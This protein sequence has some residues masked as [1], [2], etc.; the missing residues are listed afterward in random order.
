MYVQFLSCDDVDNITENSAVTDLTATARSIQATGTGNNDTLEIKTTGA[1][2]DL[3]NYA[4][5]TGWIYITGWVDNGT[6]KN[7]EIEL[8]LDGAMASN[9]IKVDMSDYVDTTRFS[10]WQR[11]TIPFVDFEGEG[12]TIDSIRIKT[13]DI[14]LGVAP[15]YWLD[16]IK[17]QQTGTSVPFTVA[18]DKGTWLHV[19]TI[20]FTF[21]DVYPG[22]VADGTF[23]SL[24]Y[25]K[26]LG[27][28]KLSAGISL[29]I[30]NGRS[31]TIINI[32]QLIDILQYPNTDV[33]DSGSDGTNTWFTII[34]KMIEPILL[35]DED[36][37]KITITIADD[38]SGLLFMKCSAGCREEVR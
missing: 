28:I 11:F 31:T 1:D 32:R 12:S 23:P 26:I 9:T 6:P 3:N 14:G 33:L 10:V 2:V 13:I 17:I 8:W 37:H 30:D 24:A 35:K 7:V 19:E 5:I 27:E 21:A 34:F 38:L 25:N 20:K 16:Y 4:S 36:E 29:N 15:N 22:T 18:P